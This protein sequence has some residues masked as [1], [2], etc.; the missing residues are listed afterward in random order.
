M[1]VVEH[2]GVVDQHVDAAIGVERRGDGFGHVRGLADVAGKE[3]GLCADLGDVRSNVLALRAVDIA[4]DEP[5][6]LAGQTLGAGAADALR[7]TCDDSGLAVEQHVQLHVMEDW[8]AAR[9][10]PDLQAE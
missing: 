3:D 7:S 2:A 8:A 10:A 4:Q 1:R 6:T 9:L 5:G